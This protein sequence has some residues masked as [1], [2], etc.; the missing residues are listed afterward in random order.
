MKVIK[1]MISSVFILSLLVGCSNST[2]EA[3]KKSTEDTSALDSSVENNAERNQTNDELESYSGVSYEGATIV[4][5]S[6][7]F[8]VSYEDT[9]QLLTVSDIAVEGVVTATENYVY[10]M[11]EVGYGTPF[12]KVTLKVNKVIKGDESLVGKEILLLEDG[13]LI[14]ARE[15][16]MADKFPDATEEQLDEVCFLI[17][18]GHKPSIPGDE[19][20]AFL[21]NNIGEEI[22]TGFDYYYFIGTYK[23]KFIYNKDTENYERPSEDFEEL[24]EEAGTK[25]EI[26]N[27]EEEIQIEE[28]INSQVTELIEE[29]E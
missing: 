23:S 13:G 15:Q 25:E 20:V 29:M 4:E 2:R 5:E 12:T 11:E 19:I 24:V 8:A 17:P 7:A 26:S 10:Y 18:D 6:L 22:Q 3:E 21:S 28:A 1:L 14:T 9:E 27:I 16:G